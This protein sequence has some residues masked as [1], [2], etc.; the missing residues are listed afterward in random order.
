MCGACM[1]PVE[2]GKADY[3]DTVQ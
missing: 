3:R 1:T 2:S